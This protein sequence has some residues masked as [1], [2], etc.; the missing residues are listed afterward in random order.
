MPPK[1]ALKYS[2]HVIFHNQL[3]PQHCHKKE[4]K[5]Q[6]SLSPMLTHHRQSQQRSAQHSAWLEVL[7]SFVH[8]SHIFVNRSLHHQ[9]WVI[10]SLS[11]RGITIWPKTLMHFRAAFRDAH[12]NYKPD[13]EFKQFWLLLPFPQYCEHS[14]PHSRRWR[15]PEDNSRTS[16]QSVHTHQHQPMRHCFFIIYVHEDNHVFGVLAARMPQ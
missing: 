7:R 14:W 13:L 5:C 3:D 10:S 11:C 12:F 15:I 16:S 8:R 4:M 2:S 6:V 1:L 9:Q